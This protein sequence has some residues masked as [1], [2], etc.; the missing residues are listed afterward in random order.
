MS[1]DTTNIHPVHAARRFAFAM[2][3]AIAA[4]QMMNE[5]RTEGCRE[6]IDTDSLRIMQGFRCPINAAVLLDTA[7][8]FWM[9]DLLVLTG[10]DGASR[11]PSDETRDL[12]VAIAASWV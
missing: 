1:N 6:F 9:F 7:N 12:A 8:G 11:R 5:F 2:E 3:L 4:E 10:R